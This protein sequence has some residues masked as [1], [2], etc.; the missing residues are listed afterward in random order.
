[1][2]ESLIARLAAALDAASLPYM[3]IGGQAVLLYGEPRLTRDVDVTLGA[4]PSRVGD[5]LDLCARLGLTPPPDPA[6]FAAETLV[7]P[8]TEEATGLRVDFIFSYEGYER[9]AIARAQTV[10]LGGVDVQ[11]VSPEDLIILKVVAGRPRDLEDVQ[12]VLVQHPSLDTAHV[13]HWLGLFEEAIEAPLL[14]RFD[15]VHRDASK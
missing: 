13:R 10:R 9:A 7:L 14:E 4:D 15:R 8:A 12:G 3:V 11:F 5:V 1:M 6:S 2:F